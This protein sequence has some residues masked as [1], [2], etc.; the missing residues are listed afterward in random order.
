MLAHTPDCPVTTE[1]ADVCT[2][3]A[4]YRSVLPPRVLTARPPLQRRGEAKG[5][6]PSSPPGLTVKEVK[7]KTGAG[8]EIHEMA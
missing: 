4:L 3:G 2:C 1:E 5:P 7:A 8:F 6:M